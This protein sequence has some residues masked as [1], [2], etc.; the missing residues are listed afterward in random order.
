M[1]DLQLTNNWD[2]RQEECD[3]HS[4]ECTDMFC[5]GECITEPQFSLTDISR[6]ISDTLRLPESPDNC[7]AQ[8]YAW[9][10]VLVYILE[11]KANPAAV[12]REVADRLEAI[13]K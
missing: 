8:N 12:L 3:V 6:S 10:A 7:E 13:A 1:D 5:E 4:E 9:S 11:N 2:W